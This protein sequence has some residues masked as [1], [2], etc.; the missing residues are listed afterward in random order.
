MREAVSYVY[1]DGQRGNLN[2]EATGSEIDPALI[3]TITTIL[4]NNN[5][6][7]QDVVLPLLAALP[8]DSPLTRQKDVVASLQALLARQPRSKNYAHVLTAA[9]AF[10]ELMNNPAI[11]KQMLAA[12]DDWI[13]T[14]SGRRYRWRWTVCRTRKKPRSLHRSS[15]TL[16]FATKHFDRGSE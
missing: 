2:I 1:K 4:A 13:A 11:R 6:N 5:E 8:E 16:E 10:P 7:A 15:D 9:A 3:R 12:L 14:C